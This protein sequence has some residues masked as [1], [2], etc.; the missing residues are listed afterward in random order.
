MAERNA[1]ETTLVNHPNPRLDGWSLVE[2]PGCIQPGWAG[3]I[4]RLVPSGRNKRI[5]GTNRSIQTVRC[6][7]LSDCAW[8][9]EPS[10]TCAQLTAVYTRLAGL[11]PWHLHLDIIAWD[12]TP[13]LVGLLLLAK[14]KDVV[15]NRLHFPN[16]AISHID[17]DHIFCHLCTCLAFSLLYADA[18]H[19]NPVGAGLSG[20]DSFLPA[21]YLGVGTTGHLP[22]G[23]SSSTRMGDQ[24]HGNELFGYRSCTIYLGCQEISACRSSLI[25]LNSIFILSINYLT[26]I[27]IYL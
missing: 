8:N 7:K 17:P 9:D 12:C 24:R 16:Q 18:T 23:N 15:A 3:Y 14:S 2:N 6:R 26:I 22:A 25:I 1:A 19:S 4:D 21:G 5:I 11:E 20:H 10:L 27:E 13:F